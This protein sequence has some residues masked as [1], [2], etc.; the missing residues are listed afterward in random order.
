M[1][2]LD[3]RE[4]SQ[5]TRARILQDQQDPHGFIDLDETLLVVDEQRAASDAAVVTSLAFF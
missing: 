4:D 1:G 5:V 2:R 3:S